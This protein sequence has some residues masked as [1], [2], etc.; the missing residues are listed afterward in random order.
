M[1]ITEPLRRAI[2]A[3]A[4]ADA[5]HELAER[6]GMHD[7]RIDGLRKALS[8]LTSIEEVERVTQ[9]GTAAD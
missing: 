1:L 3:R 7:M 9:A 2:I 8:G 4:D 6:E 5:L